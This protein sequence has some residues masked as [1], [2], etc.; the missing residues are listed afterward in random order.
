[1]LVCAVDVE[2]AG[3]ELADVEAEAD[4]DEALAALAA[5]SLRRRVGRPRPANDA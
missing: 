4:A 5:D 3:V 2:P 1:M